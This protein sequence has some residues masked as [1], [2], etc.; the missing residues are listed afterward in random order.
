MEVSNANSIITR[1]K[2]LRENFEKFDNR[3]GQLKI[4]VQVISQIQQ[5][6]M[7][8]VQSNMEHIQL[9]FCVL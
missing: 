6:N 4:N 3:I 2:Y 8:V 1:C 5:A 9:A 7:D